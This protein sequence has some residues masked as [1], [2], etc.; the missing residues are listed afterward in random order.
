M[1]TRFGTKFDGGGKSHQPIDNA[2]KYSLHWHDIIIVRLSDQSASQKRI[3]LSFACWLGWAI[4]C[5]ANVSAFAIVCTPETRFISDKYACA[6]VL[7]NTGIQRY[8]SDGRVGPLANVQKCSS[9]FTTAVCIDPTGVTDNTAGTHFYKNLT[10]S[11][12]TF[13]SCDWTPGTGYSNAQN[14]TPSAPPAP[15]AQTA[16]PPILVPFSPLTAFFTLLLGLGA[17]TSFWRNRNKSKKT[18]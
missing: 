13:Y 10:E 4:F 2:K 1:L 5:F 18:Q 14:Y 16:P 12:P 11:P 9:A 17:I 6:C 8:V 3:G 15:A 7:G